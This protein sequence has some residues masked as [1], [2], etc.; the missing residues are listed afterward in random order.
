MKNFGLVFLGVIIGLLISYG[1]CVN[2]MLPFDCCSNDPGPFIEVPT[3]NGGD[4][5]EYKN[6]S[7]YCNNYKTQFLDS[8]QSTV[9]GC[10]GGKISIAAINNIIRGA[11]HG[12]QYIFFRRGYDSTTTVTH[13]G[14]TFPSKVFTMFSLG[15]MT[16]ATSSYPVYMNSGASYCPT[17]CDAAD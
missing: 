4:T 14:S 9:Y 7:M 6:V 16:T 3:P 11:T 8:A 2:C 12:E 10:E 15:N 17:Q 13:D 5:V 1:L